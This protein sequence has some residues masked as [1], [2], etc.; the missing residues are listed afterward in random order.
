MK[1]KI[2]NIL[3][4]ALASL[5]TIALIFI[6]IYKKNLKH[7]YK[8]F[9]NISEKFCITPGL[10]TKFVPQGIAYNKKH[11]LIL[12]VGYN[13]DKTPSPIFLLDTDGNIK[14]KITIKNTENKDYTGHAGGIISFN[15][16]IFVSSG[17][18][19]YKLDMNKVLLANDNTS[20][21]A[22]SITKVD[23][24][25][26][27]MFVYD[28]YLF[29]TEFYE[30]TKYQTD[31]SHHIKTPSGDTNKA[32]AFAYEIDETNSSGLKSNEPKLVLSIPEK[33]QG[34]LVKADEII[35]STSFGRYNDSYIYKYNNILNNES[36]KT[37][38]YNDKEIPLYIMDKADITYTLLAPLMSEGMTLYNDSVL[39]LFESAAAKYRL[40]TRCKTKDIWHIKNI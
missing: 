14:K 6:M 5:I 34:L 29:V 28:K 12:V 23:T 7:S 32:I 38:K 39:I 20:V 4:I 13:S 40:T 9:V 24:D 17:K 30:E 21:K 10:D 36:T 19:V 3:L 2:L 31:A 22:D 18:K 25:G 33:V 11:N 35:L 8:D 26:A 1:K 16:I 15:D 37:F 27:T